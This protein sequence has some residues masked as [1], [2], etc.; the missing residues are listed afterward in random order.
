MVDVR[1]MYRAEI[2]WNGLSVFFCL[3]SSL[4]TTFF[5]AKTGSGIRD[6]LILP[7]CDSR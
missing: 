6:Y 3:K 5:K 4:N 2:F 7:R 1:K